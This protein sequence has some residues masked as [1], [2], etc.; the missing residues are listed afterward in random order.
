MKKS[1]LN[2]TFV[3]T[4]FLMLMSA[5][6]LTSCKKDNTEPSPASG[7]EFTIPVCNPIITDG[8]DPMNH[9]ID[10]MNFPYIDINQLIGG[11][12]EGKAD[13]EPNFWCDA[14][15]WVLGKFGNTIA[16][17]FFSP[18]GTWITTSIFGNATQEKLDKIL[19]KL[20]VIENNI[21]TLMAQTD[22]ALFLL[23][24]DGYNNLHTFYSEF[25]ALLTALTTENEIC[26][27]YLKNIYDNLQDYNE[28]E[29]NAAVAQVMQNWGNRPIE[30]N[31]AY[32]AFNQLYNKLMAP[33][34]SYYGA[35]RNMFA[36]YDVI[37][38]HNTPWEKTGYD[39]RDMF[40][41]AVAAEA[42]RTAWLT[43]LYYRTVL[44]DNYNLQDLQSE[45]TTKFENLS[46][47]FESN[48]N[49]V[50]RRY[51][52]VVCQLSGALF[53]LD[54]D[55]LEEHKSWTY[56]GS[57]RYELNDTK[58]VFSDG[59]I[60]SSSN[61]V[62]AARNSQLTNSQ[63][64]QITAYYEPKFGR[65][66]TIL[67]CLEDGGLIVPS[68]FHTVFIYGI[69]AP[70]TIQDFE[71]VYLMSQETTMNVY[72]T[73]QWSVI[74]NSGRPIRALLRL[75]GL[76]NVGIPLCCINAGGFS[77]HGSLP[78]FHV[79]YIYNEG[80]SGHLY[81]TQYWDYVPSSDD[82]IY[83]GEDMYVIKVSKWYAERDYQYTFPGKYFLWFRTGSLQT[84]DKFSFNI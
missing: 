40:R 37:V 36:V 63:I 6:V 55:A 72:V 62:T 39:M 29:L 34:P 73:Q 27:G 20:T 70:F 59:T 76:Y 19:D 4:T 15:M 68:Y 24:D 51:D 49:S 5:L 53:I 71:E 38:F 82:V 46:T 65:D 13:A 14:G 69:A 66:Y 23:D 31:S 57:G 10:T 67:N 18:L 78:D 48:S 2:N 8:C 83:I 21:S 1:L 26:E 42:V 44:K 58:H 81:G 56:S 35:N 77:C 43:A 32:G 74:L 64:S 3:R 80:E 61:D 50:N 9:V 33:G 22:Q 11:G 16:S 45:L 60:T 52:R 79:D 17:S 28:E 84:Y 12:N 75:S 47:L 25:Q 41:A 30:G 54:A 7:T